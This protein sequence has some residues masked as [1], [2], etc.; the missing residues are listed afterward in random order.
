MRD[1]LKEFT[2]H[3][4]ALPDESA[5]PSRDPLLESI[6][7]GIQTYFDKCVSSKPIVSPIGGPGTV[8]SL[9]LSI[10]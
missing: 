1:I 9:S 6:V 5:P 2:D 3:V 8:A 4:R 10:V 7:S